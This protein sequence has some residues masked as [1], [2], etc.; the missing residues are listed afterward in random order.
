MM[1]NELDEFDDDGLDFEF[2]DEV[3]K[4]MSQVSMSQ[5]RPAPISSVDGPRAPQP[6]ASSIQQQQYQQIHTGRRP[7]AVK[8]PET[9]FDAFEDDDDIFTTEME[10]LAAQVDSLDKGD[11]MTVKAPAE[12]N[13]PL[14]PIPE[15][16]GSFD[17][18]ENNLLLQI[19][20][21]VDHGN[22]GHST[23]SQVRHP[24]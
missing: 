14:P 20:D 8:A 22:T 24:R 18:G 2:F 7:A 15:L 13:Q 23:T 4:G 5:Q 6:I 3:E 11:A 1:L 21:D 10:T 16:D 17:E 12:T 9:S 19:A